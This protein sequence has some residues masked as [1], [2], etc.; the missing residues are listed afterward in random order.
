M[1]EGLERKRAAGYRQQEDRAKINWLRPSLERLM[2][3]TRE[4]GTLLVCTRR[5][6]VDRIPPKGTKALLVIE[7]N[8]ARVIIENTH[9]GDLDAASQQQLEEAAREIGDCGNVLPVCIDAIGEFDD[10]EFVVNVS[11]GPANDDDEN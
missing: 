5:V 6:P 1:G 7:G 8:T 3:S 4:A 2:R 10:A 9:L 11:V